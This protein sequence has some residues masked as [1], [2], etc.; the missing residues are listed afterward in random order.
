MPHQGDAGHKADMKQA[1]DFP[2]LKVITH[3]LVQ[4]K[5]TLM[6]DKTT[7]PILFRQLLKEIAMLIGY[8]VTR[9]LP[10]ASQPI[11]TP[12]APMNAPVLA[13]PVTI[14]SIL[15]AG[16]GM[17]D[18]LR[19]LI[20][21]A[22]EGHIGLYR[23]PETKQPHDYFLKLPADMGCAILVDPMLATGGSAAR[24]AQILL[25]HGLTPAS[26]RLVTLV[27][28]PEGMQVFAQAHPDIPVYTASLDERLDERAYIVPGLG[29][30]GDRIFGT[31]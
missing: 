22:R 31:L 18:G 3:P 8:E 21:S 14:V 16:L 19:E 6:R 17:A 15:R 28:A 7:Q 5:L 20:P 25:D 26:I 13:Q 27:S 1:S 24:A 12:L 23:N 2:S 4:H 30:A 9:D 10:L 11:E 29:D